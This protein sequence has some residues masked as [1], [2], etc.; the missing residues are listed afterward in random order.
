MVL[1]LRL[2]TT[3]ET[4]IELPRLRISVHI[5]VPSVRTDAGKLASPMVLS[6]TNRKASPAPC[7][8]LLQRTAKTCESAENPRH[9]YGQPRSQASPP[10]YRG[11]GR[12]AFT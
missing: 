10:P 1:L 12:H 3:T 7:R 5:A 4:P 2:A 8:E 11:H 6:G 9:Q